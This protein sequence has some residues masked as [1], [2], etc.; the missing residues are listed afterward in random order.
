[1]IARRNL[2]A[3]AFAAIAFPFTAGAADYPSKPIRFIIP[4]APGGA[5]SN[6]GRLVA[7]KIQKD[8]SNQ[9]IIVDNRPGA[10]TSVGME[11]TA[12]AAPDGY[13]I[14]MTSSGLPILSLTVPSFTRDA[15][16]DFTSISILSEG[17]FVIAANSAKVP[18]TT[19][20]EFIAWVRQN[21]GKVNFGAG[22]TTDQM[23]TLL[24]NERAG[25]DI[26]TIPYKGGGPATT[27]MVAGEV[28]FVILPWGTVSS[29]VNSGRARALAVTTLK[30]TAIVPGVPAIS[31]EVPNFESSFIFGVL[32]PAAMPR[33]VVSTLSRAF[34]AAM[35]DPEVVKRVNADGAD[36]IGS[37]PEEMLETLRRYGETWRPVARRLVQA[38]K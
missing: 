14:G 38:A 23:T 24:L 20:K 26:T 22:G 32:G 11:I 25:L 10:E 1:M 28:H 3:A 21:P 12:A 35:A 8:L 29:F 13:T 19:F 31:S 7:D 15:I 37:T 17:P 33:D 9:P 6:L 5:A 34:R 30:P 2:L 16:K 27:A 36:A 18:A 4:Y